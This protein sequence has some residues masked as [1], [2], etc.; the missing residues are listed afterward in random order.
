ML[1]VKA[2]EAAKPRQKP[3]KLFDG[4]GLYLEIMPTG[5]KL[6]R[7][8]YRIG[9]KDRRISIGDFDEVSLKEA[10]EEHSKV[11][12]Q[13]RQGLDPVAVRRAERT[14]KQVDTFET[15]AREWYAQQSRVWAPSH[16]NRVIRRLEK[17]IFPRLGSRPVN[18]IT[19]PEVLA[20]LRTIEKRGAHETA[21]RVAQNVG[22]V[23]R[24]AVATGRAERDASADLRGAL[25]PTKV[26][27]F[28]AIT[29]PAE[30]GALLRA[31]DG[32]QGQPMTAL[33]LRLVPLVF[34]RPGELRTAEWAEI[35][36]E[37]AT[38]I[39]PASKTKTKQDHIVPLSRQAVEI[40]RELKTM[41]GTGR[42]VFPSIRGNSRPMSDNTINA[43][44]RRLGYDQEEVTGHGFRATARTMLDEVLNER[45]DIIEAQLAHRVVGPLGR[46]YNRT[47]YLAERRAMMQ[48]WADY[49]DGLKEGAEVI[50]FPRQATGDR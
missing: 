46:A 26:K 31:V 29:E 34:V 9:E 43:A 44:L 10:R 27:H 40:L 48:R 21:H 38:W 2:I 36:L 19:A 15:V 24:Y 13:L 30:L 45:P 25:A 32:Y 37:T 6:W 17:D 3:Y 12:K 5:S 4:K 39:I 22:Q 8:R 1:T 28:P 47:T 33:A 41:T 49:L 16:G 18:E 35:D 7:I 11:R 20:V 23:L 14:A 42:Y 50:P